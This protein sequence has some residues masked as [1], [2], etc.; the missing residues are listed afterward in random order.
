MKKSIVLIVATI[1]I[2]AGA[3]SADT[4]ITQEVASVRWYVKGST[5]LKLSGTL[6]DAAMD[7][8]SKGEEVS[9]QNS[10]T[11][12][13]CAPTLLDKNDKGYAKKAGTQ[14][15]SAKSKNGKFS[16]TEKDAA[17]NFAFAIGSE[18]IKP[19]QATLKSSGT[20]QTECFTE[21]ETKMATLFDILNFGTYAFFPEK[22]GE[23]FKYSAKEQNVQVKFSANSKGK[24]NL[25][26][27]FSPAVVSPA[28]INENVYVDPFSVTN[29]LYLVIDL[30]SETNVIGYLDDVPK[31]GWTEEYKTTK[32]VLRRIEPGTFSM[33]SP[34]DERGRY[35]D[36]TQHQVTLTNAYYIG[37]FETTQKQYE[38]ITGD[39]PS[40]YK[41]GARPVESVYYNMIRGNRK[42]ASWP[43]NNDVDGNS[44]FG[45]LRAKIGLIFDLPTEAQWEY[46]CRAGTTTALNDG[47]N[48]ANI[49]SDGCL[50]KLARYYCNR[51]DGK[52]GYG[53]HTTVGSYSP[54]AWGLYDMHGNVYEWCLDWYK[55]NLGSGS[56]TDPKGP[57][58]GSYR[59][60]R[61][62]YYH[63]FAGAC[64]SACR[65]F[66]SPDNADC[67][68][69]FR[70][71]LVK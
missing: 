18:T 10:F 64:R 34:K 42:G 3:V 17:N 35:D 52:G 23:N 31:G 40:E 68:V 48:I 26:Y 1:I 4:V 50:A 29:K 43:Y 69:G 16:W 8:L 33:G 65:S 25:S 2:M 41:G 24:A 58:Y 63:T 13:L 6:N 27:K 28:V 51:D 5:T 55:S 7:A 22:K 14:N 30:L 70:V 71:F 53:E 20:L 46:A 61:G 49:Y 38:L 66:K 21:F 37:V 47:N 60:L 59:V 44:F 12:Y 36:E 39:D 67:D 19:T 32:L 56:V 45:K 11:N 15:I 9:I 62:G 54:N 57:D